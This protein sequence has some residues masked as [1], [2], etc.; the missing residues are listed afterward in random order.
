[1]S[2]AVTVPH[3]A[4]HAAPHGLVA[5]LTTVDHKRIGI[6]YGVAAFAFFLIGGLEALLIRLQLAFPDGRVVGAETFDELFTMHGTT[7]V[8]LALMPLSA[9]FFNYLVPLLIGARDVAFP[10]LNAFSYWAFLLGGLFINASFLY[11]AAPHAGWFGYAT[12]TEKPFS[13]GPHTDVW[14][15]GLLFLGVSSVVS[16]LNFL[17]TILNLRAPGMTFLRMPVF[18]WTTLVTAVLMLLAFPPIT[19]ALIL[20][21]FDRFFGT[22]FYLP[23]GGGSPVLWQHL[24]WIFGHPEVYIL[25][26]PAMG[27]VSEVLPTFARKPL[28]G[29]VAIVY[30]TS[31]IGFFGFGVWA[32]HMF[33]VGLGPIADSAF[34]LSTMI[35]AVPTG[36][37]IFNWLATV[38]GGALRFRTPLYFGLGFIAMFTIGGLS[39]IMHASPPIDLQQTDSYFVVA[40]LHYV[41][42]GGTVLGLFAGIY[43]WWPK[44]TGRMLDDRLGRLHFWLMLVSM[45]LTFFPMHFLGL[46]GMPRR[47]YT[48][49]PGLGWDFWNLVA[50]VGALGIGASILLFLGNAVRSLTRGDRASP[51]PWD[52]RTLEWAIPSPPPPYNFATVPVVRRRDALWLTKHPDQRGAGLADPEALVT[53]REAVHMPPPSAWPIRTALAM[54]I[55]A[56]GALLHDAVAALGAALTIGGVFA[57]ALEHLPARGAVAPAHDANIGSTGLDHRKMGTWAFLGSECLFF[58]TLISSYLVYK[59]RSL[60]G[61]LPHGEHGIL[62]IPLTSI[63]TFDLLMS[64]LTMVLAVAAIQRGD[65]TAARRWLLGTV[66]LGL[67]FLGGQA[68]EFNHFLHEGLGL[69]TNLFGSTFYV[70]VGFHGAHV[71]VGVLWLATLAHLVGR[72]RIGPGQAVLVDIA[73]LYWHFVD[74]VWIAIFT[75]I[76]LIR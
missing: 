17:V 1:M 30:A 42:F 12:L 37:K 67:V 55:L 36:I 47:I 66:G 2:A 34:A 50:T 45:N 60:T 61:P 62:N 14:L 40:H 13:V 22:S 58:G 54:L 51:D 3:A 53:A 73:G 68:Y 49:A 19:V 59:G 27:I 69:T 32:H 26:L 48:Y 75:L 31:L 52:G 65:L 16:A 4:T 7:M 44:M 23:A 74:V 63:S 72:G 70:L 18:V 10:R 33:A 28:F 21:M 8:F 64:S 39:G 57:L 11:G 29:Y 43:Y 15:L 38:W 25:I 35:I 56:A 71:S 6:L 46:M 41:L 76:Y 9:A 5:W 20:L 24:F